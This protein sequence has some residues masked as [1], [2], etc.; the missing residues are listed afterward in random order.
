LDGD[1]GWS[2]GLGINF[3]IRNN[4]T[5]PHTSRIISS[6][7]LERQN[8]TPRIGNIWIQQ[9]SISPNHFV[10]LYVPGV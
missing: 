9:L 2:E 5:I 10:K 8:S 1:K 4:I 6:S 7:I 3:I